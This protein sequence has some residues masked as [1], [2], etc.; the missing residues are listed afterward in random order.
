M[1]ALEVVV[2]FVRLEL[3]AGKWHWDLAVVIRAVGIGQKKWLKQVWNVDPRRCQT[4]SRMI[5]LIF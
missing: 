2:A 5:E 1:G 3:I 4:P